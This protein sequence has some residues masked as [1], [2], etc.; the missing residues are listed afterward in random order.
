M[1]RPPTVPCDP[2][3]AAAIL[4]IKD[5]CSSVVN[6][7]LNCGSRVIGELRSALGVMG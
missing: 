3:D 4:D 6:S 2:I 7:L 5:N 1:T